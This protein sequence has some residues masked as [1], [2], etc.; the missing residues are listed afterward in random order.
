MDNQTPEVQ[1]KT[2][3]DRKTDGG[4][5]ETKELKRRVRDMIQ[6]ERNLGHVDR[7][8]SKKPSTSA[9]TG[10]KAATEAAPVPAPQSTSSNKK[11]ECADCD[12]WMTEETYKG[13]FEGGH[14]GG[15]G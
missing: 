2:I 8:Y 9:E 12:N 3:W 13:D 7:D 15:S 14:A 10:A 4:F 11:T 5:P 6:P 1:S